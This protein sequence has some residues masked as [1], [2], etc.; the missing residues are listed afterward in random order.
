MN[1]CTFPG[2]PSFP[3]LSDPHSNRAQ[4][5]G[6][7]AYIAVCRR[8]AR[9][10]PIR[11]D[12]VIDAPGDSS[13]ASSAS[14][15]RVRAPALAGVQGVYRGLGDT[16]TPLWGTLACNAINL[17]L[18]PLFIFGLGWGVGG[19]ALATVVAEARCC[20]FPAFS[21]PTYVSHTCCVFAQACMVL[22]EVCI[23]QCWGHAAAD[24]VLSALREGWNN[25]ACMLVCRGEL[26]NGGVLSCRAR[27]RPGW[28]LR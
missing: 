17:A 25:I 12:H 5:S 19:A 4:S 1:S 7:L 13:L 20:R 9:A 3:S 16:R 10:Y 26:R 14:W 18:C 28:C 22:E 2:L 6:V 24:G 15:Q 21:F 8:R 23:A 27:Q 11:I